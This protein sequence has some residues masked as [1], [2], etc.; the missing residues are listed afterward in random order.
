[1]K[2]LLSAYVLSNSSDPNNLA[3]QRLKLLNIISYKLIYFSNSGF[4]FFSDVPH[5]SVPG[6]SAH[7]HFD[8]SLTIH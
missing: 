7:V 2:K 4:Y 6:I 3:H 5:T 8:E 1:M